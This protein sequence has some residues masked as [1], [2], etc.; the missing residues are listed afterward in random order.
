MKQVSARL[1]DEAARGWQL[2]C[3]ENGLSFTSL[4]E[5]WGLFLSRSEGQASDDDIAVARPTVRDT[6]RQIDA[7][8]R[9]PGLSSPESEDPSPRGKVVRQPPSEDT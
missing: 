4:M 1:S 8:R 2:Y 9:Y 6:A 7:E 5:A 3:V